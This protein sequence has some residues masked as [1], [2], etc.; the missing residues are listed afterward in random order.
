VSCR[1]IRDIPS[2]VIRSMRGWVPRTASIHTTHPGVAA[3][4]WRSPGGGTKTS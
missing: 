1:A 4:V 3:R 2:S